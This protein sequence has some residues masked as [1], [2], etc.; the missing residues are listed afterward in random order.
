[1]YQTPKIVFIKFFSL[2]LKNN[3][4]KKISYSETMFGLLLTGP[5]SVQPTKGPGPLNTSKTPS[6]YFR[7]IGLKESLIPLP[8]LLI[9]FVSQCF[10]QIQRNEVSS[11]LFAYFSSN[12]LYN[13]FV[14]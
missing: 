7:Y 6:A 14:S 13:L 9:Q 4:F 10:Q 12:L 3:F 5:M 2:F 8:K 1:M 11:N